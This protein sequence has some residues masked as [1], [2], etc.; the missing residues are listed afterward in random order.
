MGRWGRALPVAAALWLPCP[1]LAQPAPGVALTGQV[2]HPRTLALADLRALPPVTVS[3]AQ[4]TGKGV[5][6]AS[7]TG[8]LL[9]T[10]VNDAHPTDPPGERTHLQHTF[11]LRGRDGYAVAVSMGELDPDYEGKQV[12]VAY[13]KDGQPLA[14]PRLVVPADS[15]AGRGVRDLVSI[16]V[17]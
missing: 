17:R 11:L 14:E 15:H 1:T 10:L 16:E 12:L 4:V 3:V 13:A 7:Y 8:A 9:W 2:E 5:Q 6:K